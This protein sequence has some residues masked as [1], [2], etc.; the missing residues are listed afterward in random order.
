M[1]LHLI[2][3]ADGETTLSRDA[4]ELHDYQRI[5]G[6]WIE[7]VYLPGRNVIAVVNEE[8]AYQNAPYNPR[9]SVI[10]SACLGR[11]QP[12]VGTVVFVGVDDEREDEVDLPEGFLLEFMLT[13]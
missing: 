13:T 10:A 2:V 1:T 9:A 4:L 8:G 6:G 3:P 5:V 7:H 12:L 11:H